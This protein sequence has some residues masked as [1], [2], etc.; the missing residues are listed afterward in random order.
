[1]KLIIKIKKELLMRE[2]NR[3][4][5]SEEMCKIYTL[6]KLSTIKNK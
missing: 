4:D 5:S 2:D 6:T 1:M 3:E